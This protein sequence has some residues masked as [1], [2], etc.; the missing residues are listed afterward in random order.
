ML[1]VRVNIDVDD[2]PLGNACK[3]SPL[4][5]DCNNGTG[6]IISAMENM[7]RLPF[8]CG[9]FDRNLISDRPLK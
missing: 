1:M 5:L 4:P 3:V 6:C 2:D 9:D 7:V 8:A